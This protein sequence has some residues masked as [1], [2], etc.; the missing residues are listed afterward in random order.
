M[1]RIILSTMYSVLILHISL[2]RFADRSCNL[3]GTLHCGGVL[4]W[5]CAFVFD[6][7]ISFPWRVSLL[8]FWY[9]AMWH[10]YRVMTC[11]VCSLVC[12]MV[13]PLWCASTWAL[14]DCTA[15]AGACA[16]RSINTVFWMPCSSIV[17]VCCWTLTMRDG[18]VISRCN[19]LQA[20]FA[21][22]SAAGSEVATKGS[23]SRSTCWPAITVG[24]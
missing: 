23:L 17:K 12:W 7:L 20:R 5:V 10:F 8:L 11:A 2:L 22:T 9:Y 19:S 3:S 21:K 14:L 13:F 18:L 16:T 24:I 1:R 15:P 4:L 6:G